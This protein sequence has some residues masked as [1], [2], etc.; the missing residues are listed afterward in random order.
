MHHNVRMGSTDV[1]AQL[2]E[3]G[4]ADAEL[5]ARAGLARETVARW[6]S[7]AQRPSL[8]AL[9]ELATAAG[10]QLDVQVV[11]ADPE[12]IALVGDQLDLDPM[13]RL[14]ALRGVRAWRSC[15]EALRGAATLKGVVCS[16]PSA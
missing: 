12:H 11:K 13:E 6:R 8:D 4:L 5:A 3:L 14:Q 16:P 15:R 1:M 9:E 10:A 2:R 7:G